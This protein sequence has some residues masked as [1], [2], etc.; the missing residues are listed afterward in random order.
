[1]GFIDKIRL[2]YVIM[3]TKGGVMTMYDFYAYQIFLGRRTFDQAPEAIKE[4]VAE[5]LKAND[6]G[7]LITDDRY[8]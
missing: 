8:K 6:A 5:S 4:R 2:V 3:T 7:H 1:M